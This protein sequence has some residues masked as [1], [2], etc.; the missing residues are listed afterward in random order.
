MRTW[1]CLSSKKGVIYCFI[2]KLF[3]KTNSNFTTGYSD[4]KHVKDDVN[5]H[6]NSDTHRNAYAIIIQRCK[7]N[8]NINTCLSRQIEDEKL[9]WRNVIESLISV[10]QFLCQRGLAFRGNNEQFGN[11]NNGNYIGLLELIS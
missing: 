6:E 1:I 8:N 7:D 2:C 3:S 10:I 4:W 9:Y 11:I 5:S